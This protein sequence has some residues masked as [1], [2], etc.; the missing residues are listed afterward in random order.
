M[1][2][3]TIR[4]GAAASAAAIALAACGGHGLVPSQSA[5]PGFSLISDK[6]STNPCLAKGVQPAWV[7]K[8]ACK[9]VKLPAKG[10]TIKLAAYKG[11]TVTASF[12][13]NNSK[14]NPSFVLVDALGGKTKDIAPFKKKAFPA[15]PAALGKS[16][17]NIQAVNSFAGLKFSGGNLV[18]TAKMGK[19]PGSTCKVSLLQPKG[20]SKYQWFTIPIPPKVKGGTLTE[21]IPAGAIGTLYANGLPVAPLFFNAACK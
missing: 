15:I 8:G 16:V 11:I 14:G 12:P 7:F 3:S 13:K 2:F 21:T 1:R 6:S 5:A 19:L 17:I 10:I 4:T 9:I 18:V 20:G